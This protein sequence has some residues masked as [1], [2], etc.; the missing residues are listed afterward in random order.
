MTS[1]DDGL[2][3]YRQDAKALRKRLKS[4]LYC[5]SERAKNLAFRRTQWD[6]SALRASEWHHQRVL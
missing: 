6:S 3:I 1:L 5:H 4:L 2:E